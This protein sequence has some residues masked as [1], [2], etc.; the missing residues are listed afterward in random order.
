MNKFIVL[1]ALTICF[2]AASYA[3][4]VRKDIWRRP[5]P[6]QLAGDDIEADFPWVAAAIGAYKAY[7]IYK[8]IKDKDSIESDFYWN[9]P[10]GRPT[11]ID[12][13]KE[14]WRR[15][16]Q[17]YAAAVKVE[18]DFPWVA[19]AI[20]AYKLYKSIKKD[21]VEADKINWGKVF[22]PK[23]IQKAVEIYKIIRS[24]AVESD[25]E[26]LGGLVKKV[27]P[28]VKKGVDIYNKA[29]GLGILADNHERKQKK[30]EK[31]EPVEKKEKKEKK[32]KPVEKKK[33]VK[34]VEKKEKKVKPVKKEKKEKKVKPV[35]KRRRKLEKNA[36]PAE[37]KEKKVKP[38]KKEKKEKKVKPVE[39]KE[40]K[41][42]KPESD[43]IN[44]GKVFSP[45]NIQKAVE[46]YKVIRSDAVE[47]DAEAE[48]FKKLG[49]LVK[50]VAPIAKKGFDI[51]K[52]AKGFGILSESQAGC[53]DKVQQVRNQLRYGSSKSVEDLCVAAGLPTSAASL[54]RAGLPTEFICKKI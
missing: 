12:R 20:G 49:G 32:V 35:E 51:Y 6:K 10:L 27:A 8:T 1:F 11:H 28:V 29:K 45:K 17:K 37:K 42:N 53:A 47:S 15:H 21:E 38:V 54:I 2:V 18:A 26:K 7:K 30:A 33:K 34:P 5:L 25:S 9:A 23:N 36:K 44:W 46:I 50:K 31:V 16:P 14:I 39:K 13:V 22:S 4:V 43:K 52:K 40:K 41:A 48:F 24:D 19:A 3:R